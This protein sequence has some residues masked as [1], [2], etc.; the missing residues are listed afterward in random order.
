MPRHLPT[1]ITDRHRRILDL[2]DAHPEGRTTAQIQAWTNDM[3]PA[4]TISEIRALLRG[5]PFRIVRTFL[6]VRNGRKV[7]QY[8]LVKEK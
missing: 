4:T 7:H 1:M 6:G 2:L 5:T 3:S 8:Q